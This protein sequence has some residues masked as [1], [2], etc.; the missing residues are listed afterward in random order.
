M[1]RAVRKHL[2]NEGLWNE[3]MDSQYSSVGGP[4]GIPVDDRELLLTSRPWFVWSLDLSEE[5]DFP[6][7]GVNEANGAVAVGTGH[8]GN[9]HNLNRGLFHSLPVPLTDVEPLISDPPCNSHTTGGIRGSYFG[10]RSGPSRINFQ[11]GLSADL[12]RDVEPSTSAPQGDHED[13]QQQNN[14]RT[15]RSHLISG[16][17]HP[18]KPADNLH[19]TGR[20]RKTPSRISTH[21]QEPHR[22]SRIKLLQQLMETTEEEPQIS[23]PMKLHQGEKRKT[24]QRTMRTMSKE[25]RGRPKKQNSAKSTNPQG[26]TKERSRP[27]GAIRSQNLQEVIKRRG[28]PPKL[29]QRED[30]VLKDYP[31]Q[32]VELQKETKRKGG[33]PKSLQ[34]EDIKLG[35]QVAKPIEL[36]K[37]TPS[38]EH[39]LHNANKRP[40]RPSKSAQTKIVEPRD[41]VQEVSKRRGRPPKFVE[42]ES[43]TKGRNPLLIS[44][45]PQIIIKRRGRPP[46]LI[47]SQKL[48]KRSG[49]P[50]TTAKPQSVSKQ[51]GRPKT[52]LNA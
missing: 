35:G 28:C 2:Q 11:V 43:V 22:G 13:N 38:E 27:V 12:D 44:E 48:N 25:R 40:G 47:T 21:A 3:K 23:Q 50:P 34:T 17:T 18:T 45:E 52:R 36:Q 8:F 16:R 37:W 46:K 41:V 33:P 1:E 4:A 15:T 42:L 32:G 9:L 30:T 14:P 19:H 20:R 26:V 51:R 5:K 29:V 49:P 6:S 39:E 10:N 7:H 31:T 24:P